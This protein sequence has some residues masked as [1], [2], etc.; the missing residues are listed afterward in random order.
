MMKFIIETLSKILGYDIDVIVNPDQFIFKYK[1]ETLILKTFIY[2]TYDHNDLRILSVGED[3]D[4]SEPYLKIDLFRPNH[5]NQF[6]DLNK[7]DALAA[8]LKYSSVRLIKHRLLVRPSFS[9]TNSASLN[10]S[11]FAPLNS[12]MWA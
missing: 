12:K 4:L 8:F 5:Q 3:Y 6:R 10:N 9:F 2:I 11:S 1:S 7:Y